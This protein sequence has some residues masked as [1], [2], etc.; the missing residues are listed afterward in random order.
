MSGILYLCS[1]PIGNLDDISI[2]T[3]NILKTVDIIAA[4]DTRNTI[5]ILNHFNINTKMTSYHEHNKISKGIQLI[6]K[7]LD[8]KNIALVTDAGTPGISDP[9]ED[10]VSLA[11][12]NN[13]K[14]TSTPGPTAF[15]T[16]LII[17]GMKTR[18]FIFEGFLPADKKERT[19]I[20]ESLKYETRTTIFYEAPHRLKNTLAELYNILGNRNIAIARELTKKFEEVKKDNLSNLI[21]F[22]SS[23]EPKGEFVIILE[24]VSEEHI[25]TENQKSWS[26]ISIEE[27]MDIYLN[28]EIDTK[29]AMK[30]VA[31]D[32]GI[33][34]REIYS[35][36]NKK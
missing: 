1:T 25:K 34:K 29:E 14:V 10:L 15:T 21:E 31:R 28:Q 32:R 13:I 24:G 19:H 30:R 26:S 4:E 20:I 2:R 36:L 11:I 33:T 9:G 12:E 23:N 3:L 8:N 18:R 17:S 7:L 22:Y 6:D 27:H 35:Y 5:K 16:A